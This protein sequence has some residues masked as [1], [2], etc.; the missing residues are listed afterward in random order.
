MDP[1]FKR[2]MFAGLAASITRWVE[3][4][5]EWRVPEYPAILKQQ[6][7]PH[8]PSNGQL[9]SIAAPL[10]T[11]LPR[12]ARRA[13]TKKHDYAMGASMYSLPT[14]LKQTVVE[15]IVAES[16]AG[17]GDSHR[18]AS[19]YVTEAEQLPFQTDIGY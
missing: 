18:A 14:L 13:G 10:A 11:W 7:D 2:Q 12:D 15:A 17:V 4:A 9:I 8:I 5:L 6:L 19:P 3:L 16:P 1:K